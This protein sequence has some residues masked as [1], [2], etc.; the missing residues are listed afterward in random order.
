MYMCV[1]VVNVHSHEKAWRWMYW[2]VSS[3]Y[4]CLLELQSFSSLFSKFSVIGIVFIMRVNY[5]SKENHAKKYIY[6]VQ[7]ITKKKKTLVV[8]NVT[9]LHFSLW[10]VWE[11]IQTQGNTRLSWN[12]SLSFLLG[13]NMTLI[14]HVQFLQ[15]NCMRLIKL[16]TFKYIP[17]MLRIW[18]PSITI[19]SISRTL[20][21]SCKKI[22][23]RRSYENAAFA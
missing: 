23:T 16:G 4:L 20:T 22:Q 12:I 5:I 21:F 6:F 2:L 13:L 3:Y 10:F 7:E 1:C 17:T 8:F 19:Q 18:L 9:S 15:V 14:Q 11:Q